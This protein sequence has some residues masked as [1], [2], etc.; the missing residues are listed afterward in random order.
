MLGQP[1]IGS[2]GLSGVAVVSNA[3]VEKI[4]E[5]EPDLIIGLDNIENADQLSRA[6]TVLFTYGEL[7]YWIR[8]WKSVK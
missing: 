8:S 1:G 2:E 4:L 5:L 6:P 3:D 7:S